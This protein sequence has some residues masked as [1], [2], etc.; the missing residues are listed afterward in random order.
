MF[1]PDTSI[2]LRRDKPWDAGTA[3]RV[4]FPSIHW[5]ANTDRS[6]DVV[7]LNNDHIDKDLDG[8]IIVSTWYTTISLLCNITSSDATLPC[9][10]YRRTNI[11]MFQ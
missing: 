9:S 10:C 8:T 2:K 5:P 11:V 3:P 1:R 7:H 6:M 4:V